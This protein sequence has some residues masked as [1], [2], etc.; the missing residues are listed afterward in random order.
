MIHPRFDKSFRKFREKLTTIKVPARIIFI[1]M[2]ILSTAWFLIR[3]IPKPQRAGYPCMKAAFPIMSGFIIWLLSVSGSLTAFRIARR[4]MKS[5]RYM[6]GGTFAVLAVGLGI[7]AFVQHQ[8]KVEAAGLYV[9]NDYF[10]PN[11]PEGE[12]HGIHPGRVVWIHNPDATNEDCPND[13]SS[14]YYSPENN[15]Q[16]VIDNM[17]D[18]SLLLLT[19]EKTLGDA[20]DAIF[21]NFNK[22]K[23]KGG[24]GYKKGETIFI[25]V[26]QGTAS[27]LSDPTTLNHDFSGWHAEWSPVSETSAFTMLSILRNLIDTAGVPQ[28]DIYLGDPI[29]HIWQDIYE[30]LHDVYPDVHYV[31]RDPKYE[32]LGRSTLDVPKDPVIFYS[33]NGTVMPDAIS[34]KLYTQMQD[35]NYMINMAALKAHARAGIT[36]TAKNHFGS[37]TRLSAEHLHPSHPSPENDTPLE[38]TTGY[39]KYR[40]F[41]D[42]MGHQLLGQNTLLYFIDGLW[43]GGEATEPPVKF[44]SPPFNDDWSNSVI[45]SLDQ[46][47]LESVCFDILRTEFNDP[48][49]VK[50]YRPHLYGADDYLHQAADRANWPEGILY[51]PEA[52]GS[53]LKSLGVNEHWNDA[54]N[55]QYSRNLGKDYGIELITMPK[56]L[57]EDEPFISR[58][59]ATIPV[60]DGNGDD[61]CWKSADWYGIDN[62]WIPWGGSVPASDY[63]GSFKSLWS[64]V[65]NKIYFLVRIHD[66]VFIDGYHYPD[67]GYP[68]FDVVEVFIDED[69]SGGPHV[70]DNPTTGENG[71]NAFSYHI[72][73]NAPADGEVTHD[74]VACDLAGHSWSDY[75]VA[76]YASH[77]EDFSMRKDGDTYTYEFSLKVYNSTYD[78]INPELS[79]DTLTDGKIMGISLAYCDNDAPDGQ[80]D[81]FFGSVWVTE[82][83]YN[84]HWENS[85]D[86][87]KL[88]LF[89]SSPAVNHPPLVTG[90]I[91]D[92]NIGEY[93]TEVTLVDDLSSWF[94]D[95]DGDMLDYSAFDTDPAVTLTVRDNKLIATAM[96]SFRGHSSVS[97]R[98]IDPGALVTYAHFSLTANNRSPILLQEIP[99]YTMM[100]RDEYTVVQDILTIFSDPDSDALTFT[101]ESDNPDVSVYFFGNMLKVMAG[102]GFNGDET[103][104][105][106]VTA[107]DGT[108]EVSTT[109]TV[110]LETTGIEHGTISG[111][112]V[113]YPN[114]VTGGILNVRFSTPGTGD[115]SMR[116]FNLNGQ[117]VESMMHT[118]S[119]SQFFR[120]IDVSS[121]G[122]GIYLLEIGFNG[123]KA[124]YRFTK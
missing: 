36:L 33:D 34:D 41:V 86:Y 92:V 88:V 71:E 85:N 72:L 67:P 113:C 44:T 5:Q 111:S 10:I 13:E 28:Q 37:H 80:R 70:F 30:Y 19:G 93:G 97:V 104:S 87:G 124:V 122:S 107:S 109:F 51:D 24:K 29:A 15:N 4:N 101:A 52:D 114:P 59:A 112:L 100:S 74:F 117:E 110:D 22:M 61:D 94:S 47:A 39:D 54:L 76:N 16:S 63:T 108:E 78:T 57:A 99:D 68:D 119:S 7:F 27:W 60:F 79:R 64:A 106:T 103:A 31:D 1:I 73:A 102:E 91:P 12:P 121:L 66:D 6:I 118:K 3:V 81:N 14:P 32:S 105:V 75:Y 62:T 40:V 20:W 23:G 9:D 56:N 55:R 8:K 116:V 98:A 35:A 11:Q 26:N 53:I 17:V 43:G 58:E 123:E 46:V 83:N 90:Q 2:G 95:E 25:K 45:V 96:E 65:D 42:I 77:I 115:V 18:S 50:K 21:I 89:P 49:D 38:S 82:E 120:S 84:S 69:K 48:T